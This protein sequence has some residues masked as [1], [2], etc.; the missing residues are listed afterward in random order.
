MI[1]FCTFL[2]LPVF[3]RAMSNVLKDIQYV[4]TLTLTFW[5]FAMEKTN[6][7]TNF[8]QKSRFRG[9]RTKSLQIAKKVRRLRKKF[10]DC[11]KTVRIQNVC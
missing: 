10:A 11:E 5:S 2:W 6:L 7:R 8:P 3:V 9:L 1:Q 4:G